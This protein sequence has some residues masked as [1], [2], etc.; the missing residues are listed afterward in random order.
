MAATPVR[1]DDGVVAATSVLVVCAGD[2]APAAEPVDSQAAEGS[3]LM[4]PPVGIRCRSGHLNHPDGLYCAVCGIGLAQS[5]GVREAGT[6]P[7]AGVLVVDDG[8][9]LPMCRPVICGSMP[10]QAHEVQEGTVDGIRL[11]GA[12]PVQCR[13]EPTGWDVTVTNVSGASLAVR[14]RGSAES[15][16]VSPGDRAVLEPGAT[17]VLGER[18]LRFD[19]H[20]RP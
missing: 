2:G 10:E 8:S 16:D 5:G 19:T 6:L 3:E 20:L 14:H 12:L 1:L 17:L 9:V 15:H 7:P 4:A 11:P 18:W 13:V